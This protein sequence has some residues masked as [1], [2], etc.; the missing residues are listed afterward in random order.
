MTI[1]KWIIAGFAALII[2]GYFH[3]HHLDDYY[4]IKVA[5][6]QVVEKW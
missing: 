1:G 5:V 3:E 4:K 2:F 6:K